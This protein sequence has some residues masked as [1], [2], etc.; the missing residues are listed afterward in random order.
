LLQW[1]RKKDQPLPKKA[2]EA[3]DREEDGTVILPVTPEPAEKAE[4]LEGAF[5]NNSY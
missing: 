4:E 5:N 3:E 2:D 1:T